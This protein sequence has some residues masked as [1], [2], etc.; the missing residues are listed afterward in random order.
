M[1]SIVTKYTENCMFC[2]RPTTTTHHLVF[3]RG[4]RN[5]ADEDGL[6]IPVCDNCHTMNRTSNK[7]HDNPIAES[8]SKMLGQLAYEKHKVAE[9]MSEEEA[10]ESFRKRYT[11]SYL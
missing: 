6:V 2:G 4:M 11:R 10:R 3:G 5:I 1:K 7:I 9:G 8:F